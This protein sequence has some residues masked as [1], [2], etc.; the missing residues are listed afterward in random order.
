MES[1][2]DNEDIVDIENMLNVANML[3]MVGNAIGF[4]EPDEIWSSSSDSE[5]EG[6]DDGAG[7]PLLLQD[8]VIMD[9]NLTDSDADDDDWN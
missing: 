1:N 7:L 9:F 6:L 8:N 2:D 5:D 4:D 3:G